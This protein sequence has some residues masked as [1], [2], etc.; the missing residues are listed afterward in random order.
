[1]AMNVSGVSPAALSENFSRREVLPGD[2]N[3]FVGR[4][5]GGCYSITCRFSGPSAGDSDS[6]DLKGALESLGLT[7]APGE[8]TAGCTG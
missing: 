3:H 2:R 5:R 4:E 7:G 8:L 1:M 6:V